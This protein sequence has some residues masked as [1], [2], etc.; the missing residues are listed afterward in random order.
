MPESDNDW[1]NT[2]EGLGV[3]KLGGS[4]PIRAVV[5]DLLACA[6][7]I[8][9]AISFLNRAL[10]PGFTLVPL[11]ILS[12]IVPWRGTLTETIHNDLL[13][14]VLLEFYPFRHFYN[15]KRLHSALGYCPPNEFEESLLVRQNGVPTRQIALTYSV[16]T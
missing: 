13:T 4:R 3:R 10:L 9:L 15:Q 12:A 8:T 1:G 2:Q 7:I 5:P 11:D 14:D 16:Q 6:M